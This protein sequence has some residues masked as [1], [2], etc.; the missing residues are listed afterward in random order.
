MIR[1]FLGQEV[2]VETGAIRFG[3]DWPGTFIR[4]DDSFHLRLALEEAIF[5]LE[6][7]Q[8]ASLLLIMTLK[9]F[10]KVLDECN[11]NKHCPPATVIPIDRASV[12]ARLGFPK[13]Q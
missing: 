13:R 8:D 12:S 10:A 9:E 6:K 4:G 2:R 11:L 7:R 5:E 3:D 1:Q